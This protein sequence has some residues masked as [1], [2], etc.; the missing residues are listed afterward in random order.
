MDRA[1]SYPLKGPGALV[2]QRVQDGWG[3]RETCCCLDHTERG[4]PRGR[5]Q[6]LN[7]LG[8]PLLDVGEGISDLLWVRVSR[9]HGGGEAH[10]VYERRPKTNETTSLSLEPQVRRIATYSA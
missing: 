10:A 8:A 2:P 7:P 5:G 9:A 4:F 6:G 3:L 1:G